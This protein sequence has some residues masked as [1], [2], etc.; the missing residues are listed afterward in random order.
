MDVAHSERAI[1]ATVPTVLHVSEC[2]GGGV[3]TAVMAYVQ[4]TPRYAHWFLTASRPSAG[5][6][7]DLANLI[8]GWFD[9]PRGHLARI[10]A[11]GQAYAA[12][13]PDVVHAHSS[14]AGVYVRACLSVP[15]NRIVY[16][17]HCYA[18]ERADVNNALRRVFRVTEAVLARRTHTI[19]AV[20]P[21]EA[22]LA[23]SLRQT[24]RVVYIPNAV[25]PCPTIAAP[26]TAGGPVNA[27]AVGRI[28]AQKDPGFLARAADLAVDAISWTW[29]GGGDD[30]WLRHDLESAGVHVTGWL[31]RAE[32][33]RR[34]QA[35]DVYVHTARWEG[36]PMSLLEAVAAGLPVVARDIPALRALGVPNLVRT[37][38]DLAE[39]VGDLADPARCNEAAL[40]VRAALCD[41]TV[42]T[43]AGRLPQAY[44][45]V[46]FDAKEQE[47]W[48]TKS[49]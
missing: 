10:S 1:R 45:W 6:K 31:P 49:G 32:V 37:P 17:P 22:S 27:V 42:E 39:A 20:S 40:G 33:L 12:L 7:P 18:F 35:S 5:I 44:G 3:S 46:G 23:A 34:V 24:Q 2:W 4:A 25:P 16:T 14:F 29:I 28:C 13:K 15:T 41:N 8:R 47:Q 19:A 11:V 30:S 38:G 43:L 48:L 36:A 21:R 9:L 26:R